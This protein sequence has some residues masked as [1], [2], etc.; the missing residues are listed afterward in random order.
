MLRL[1]T[2]QQSYLFRE[3]EA[4]LHKH[5]PT[6]AFGAMPDFPRVKLRQQIFMTQAEVWAKNWAKNWAKF[7][8]HVLRGC[9]KHGNEISMVMFGAK[10]G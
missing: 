1:R 9:R 6:T 7:S 5:R 10:F 8:A 4:A 2:K 3:S